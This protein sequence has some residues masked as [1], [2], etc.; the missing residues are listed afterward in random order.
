MK[1]NLTAAPVGVEPDVILAAAAAAAA[2]AASG[3]AVGCR[4]DL[5][6]LRDYHGLAVAEVP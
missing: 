1:E 5:G 2:A 3:L 6:G 4:L